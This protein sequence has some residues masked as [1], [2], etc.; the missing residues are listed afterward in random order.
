[1]LDAVASPR[2]R[3]ALRAQHYYFVP[4]LML[5]RLAWAQQ[6]LAHAYR[7]GAVRP[8]PLL[9]AHLCLTAGDRKPNGSGVNRARRFWGLPC[10]GSGLGPVWC[11]NSSR[12]CSSHLSTLIT[13]VSCGL[14]AGIW[15]LCTLNI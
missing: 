13:W 2:V 7:L 11:Q 1:M 4:I 10:L 14:K 5:A 8:S 15:C 12:P 9:P 3:R 6:S